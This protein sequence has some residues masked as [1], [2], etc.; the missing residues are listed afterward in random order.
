MIFLIKM[1]LIILF[2]F[3]LNLKA[4]TLSDEDIQYYHK[5]SQNPELKKEHIKKV[6]G[7]DG[8]FSLEIKDC[9]TEENDKVYQAV[10]ENL[11]RS[12]EQFKKMQEKIKENLKNNPT[13]K[14]LEQLKIKENAANVKKAE[15]EKEKTKQKQIEE[16]IKNKILLLGGT[17]I[18]KTPS[19]SHDLYLSKLLSQ[20]KILELKIAEDKIKKEK[21]KVAN[22]S[23]ETFAEKCK[24]QKEKGTIYTECMD[25]KDPAQMETVLTLKCNLDGKT[26]Y[27]NSNVSITHLIE[28]KL[29]Q[30]E[31]K[32]PKLIVYLDNTKVRPWNVL[33]R[34]GDA[35]YSTGKK[36]KNHPETIFPGGFEFIT[37]EV[38]VNMRPLTL[39]NGTD[40]ATIFYDVSLGYAIKEKKGNF[41]LRSYFTKIN[42]EIK[43]NLKP[44]RVHPDYIQDKCEIY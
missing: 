19:Y 22:R 29:Y 42:R 21:E 26:F 28:F 7:G 41:Y 20:K 6:C 18:N 39:D 5:L 8:N 2:L 34:M 13:A 10:M 9:F 11:K 16:E 38:P 30:S 36:D 1:L 37:L 12:D 23:N 32:K 40:P 24:K 3:N 33:T 44:T 15:E 31:G 43:Q 14:A 4:K 25:Y 35:D 17:P 27:T